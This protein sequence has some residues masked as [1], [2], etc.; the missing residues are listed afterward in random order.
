MTSCRSK[1]LLFYLYHMVTLI[2]LYKHHQWK[3]WIFQNLTFVISDFINESLVPHT[4]QL[5]F[6]L[7]RFLKCIIPTNKTVFTDRFLRPSPVLS[8]S[9]LSFRKPFLNESIIPN[10][11]WNKYV[12]FDWFHTIWDTKSLFFNYITCHPNF[13]VKECKSFNFSKSC[14]HVLIVS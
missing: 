2:S 1:T 3:I 11:L 8:H 4:K 13:F 5:S 10:G 7:L 14:D 6:S 12:A 9:T